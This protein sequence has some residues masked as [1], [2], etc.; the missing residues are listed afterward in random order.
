MRLYFYEVAPE[1]TTVLCF[2]RVS[3]SA[4]SH[5]SHRDMVVNNYNSIRISSI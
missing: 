3:H 5:E 2:Q 1:L 4:I